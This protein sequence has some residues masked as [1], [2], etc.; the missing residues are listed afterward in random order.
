VASN[1]RTVTRQEK[2]RLAACATPLTHNECDGDHVLLAGDA[3]CSNFLC[4]ALRSAPLYQACELFHTQRRNSWAAAPVGH[5]TF[6]GT[7]SASNSGP[8][9]KE[10]GAAEDVALAVEP[11]TVVGDRVFERVDGREVLVDEWLVGV[12]PPVLG[13]LELG[14]VGRREDALEAIWHVDQRAGVVAGLIEHQHDALV[15]PTPT[16]AAKDSK[17]TLMTAVVMPEVH[18]H[19]VR[20]EAGWTKASTSRH[21]TRCCTRTSGR[22]P[23]A[24]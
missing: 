3:R 2:G 16:A 18:G 10:G 17:A 21:G 1:T 15:W 9:V 12:G 20:P 7:L 4:P 11:I 13:G 23:A 19:A 22:G 5:T 8:P 6:H 24:V 14:R